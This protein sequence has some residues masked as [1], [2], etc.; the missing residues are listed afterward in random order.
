MR[1]LPARGKRQGTEGAERTA[2][3]TDDRRRERREAGRRREEASLIKHRRGGNER[4]IPVHK[5]CF[6]KASES[7]EEAPRGTKRDRP[8]GVEGKQ[9]RSRGV[10][11]LR[12]RPAG[13]PAQPGA[14]LVPGTGLP[15]VRTQRR[16]GEHLARGKR[17]PYR[18]ATSNAGR[19]G[20]PA[21]GDTSLVPVSPRCRRSVRGD[22]GRQTRS[23]GGH[24]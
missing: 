16:P 21:P 18:R 22:G 23:L 19:P 10:P 8:T 24:G 2:A 15:P 7:E 9:R 1:G 12:E 11:P 17:D 5:R 6:T 20:K 13:S 14:P 4:G 3:M